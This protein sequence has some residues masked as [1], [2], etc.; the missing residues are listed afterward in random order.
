MKHFVL[1]ILISFF[2][3]PLI[4]AQDIKL[5]GT[6][7]AENNQIKNTTDPT[8]DQDVATKNYVDDNINSFSGSYNDLTDTPTIYTQAQV[9]R[10]NRRNK[11]RD[12]SKKEIYPVVYS[13][14]DLNPHEHYCSLDFKSN[15]STNS[16][17]R[18][19]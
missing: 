14:R 5:N 13:R 2:A 8:D 7:S 4:N 16:T 18:A 1:T 6:I 11:K 15:V 3:L 19:F 9:N 12:K 10:V 17:T